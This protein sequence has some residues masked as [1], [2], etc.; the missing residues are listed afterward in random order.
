MSDDSDSHDEPHRNAFDGY[1]PNVA[2]LC[3]I[4]REEDAEAH[5]GWHEGLNI[6]Y[7]IIKH[8]DA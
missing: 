2:R 6:R 4:R 8:M 1:E 7:A 3:K 5:C